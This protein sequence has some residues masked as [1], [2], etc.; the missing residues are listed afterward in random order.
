MSPGRGAARMRSGAETGRP[1]GPDRE[2]HPIVVPQGQR[3]SHSTECPSPHIVHPPRPVRVARAP[4]LKRRSSIETRLP[5]VPWSA[6][7][8]SLRIGR[9]EPRHE[10]EQDHRSGRSAA[11]SAAQFAG[12]AATS[13]PCD[14]VRQT[15]NGR[16]SA[17][18]SARGQRSRGAHPRSARPPWGIDVASNRQKE[19]Q[20]RSGRRSSKIC[21]G[22]VT[23]RAV[24]SWARPPT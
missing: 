24:A 17:S 2:G 13:D 21:D 23:R 20:A 15:V 12:V 14:P 8:T 6:E 18:V 5:P 3:T 11:S 4:P 7:V 19:L 16:A 1:A 9:R 10:L 22:Q